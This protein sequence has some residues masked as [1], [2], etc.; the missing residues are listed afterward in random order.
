MRYIDFKET[1]IHTKC[2]SHN[3]K[4]TEMTSSLFPTPRFLSSYTSPS[5]SY[6]GNLE[7]TISRH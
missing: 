2:P 5:T 4:P 6:G 7:K 1:S 3:I